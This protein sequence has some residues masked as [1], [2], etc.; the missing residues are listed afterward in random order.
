MCIFSFLFLT[1]GSIPDPSDT[2]KK[3]N[4]TELFSWT[5]VRTLS[6][7]STSIRVIRLYIK[8]N[9]KNCKKYELSWWCGVQRHECNE[10]RMKSNNR[11]TVI[12][13]AIV[14]YII[15]LSILYKQ[16]PRSRLSGTVSKLLCILIISWS[17]LQVSFSHCFFNLPL[18]FDNRSWHEYKIL[19]L[20]CFLS[21]S[22]FRSTFSFLENKV[23]F[24]VRAA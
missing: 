15:P 1:A 21:S 10:T 16:Y 3:N 22:F 24:I 13:A 9:N 6:I 14:I 12:Y 4:L 18:L 8:K 7:V 11:F 20:T 5:C 17:S 23:N 19:I 2:D